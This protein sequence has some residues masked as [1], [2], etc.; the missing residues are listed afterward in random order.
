[1]LN[2]VFGSAVLGIEADFRFGVPFPS[3]GKLLREEVGTLIGRKK[4][5]I[6]GEG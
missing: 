4:G 2:Q 5:A 6:G 3:L 1:M